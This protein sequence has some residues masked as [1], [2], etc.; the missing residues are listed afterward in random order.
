MFTLTL[1]PC[2]SSRFLSLPRMFGS[3][4]PIPLNEDGEPA[5]IYYLINVRREWTRLRAYWTVEQTLDVLL[6]HRL[7]CRAAHIIGPLLWQLSW[8]PIGGGARSCRRRDEA[9]RISAS[10]RRTMTLCSRTADAHVAHALAA[11]DANPAA[12]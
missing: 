8:E 2:A 10:P 5:G 6:T 12:D 1:E 7:L 11:A 3:G 9:P 4:R